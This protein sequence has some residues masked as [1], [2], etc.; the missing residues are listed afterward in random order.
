MNIELYLPPN[1]AKQPLYQ[2]YFTLL[3]EGLAARSDMTLSTQ[4][5]QLIHVFGAWNAQTSKRITQAHRRLIPTVYSPLGELAPWWFHQQKV[6]LSPTKLLAQKNATKKA[7]TVLVW[8]ENER[9]SIQ[10][11]QWS[12]CV[13]LIPNP[14][15]TATI[16][17]QDCLEQLVTLYEQTILE[18]DQRMRQAI[19]KKMTVI[20]EDAPLE[21]EFCTQVLYLRYQYHRRNISK[22]AL[23]QLATSLMTVDYDEDALVQMLITLHEE[24]FT[25]RILQLL[26]EDKQITEGF[27]PLNP[28]DDKHTKSLREAVN[29]TELNTIK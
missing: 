25:A 12:D 5:P 24:K 11:R 21:K 2:Q 4:F 13:S 28:L 29:T 8:G 3:E 7:T 1:V 26:E 16:T 19:A 18:H 17:P 14:I 23:A 20:E 27:M 15:L 10:Q 22:A 6:R 9:R